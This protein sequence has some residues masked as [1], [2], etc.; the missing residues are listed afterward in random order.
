MGY[1]LAGRTMLFDVTAHRWSGEI[2]EAI[3]LEESRLARALPSGSVSGTLGRSVASELGLGEGVRLVCGGHDQPCGALGAGVTE[4]GVAMYATGS[5]EC[6]TPAFREP[7]FT[8]ELRRNNLCT[9]DHAAAGMYTTVA[10]SLTGGNLL[11]WFRDQFGG[12]EAARAEATGGNAYALL[13]ETAGDEPSPLLALPYLT[14][15]GTPHF[16]PHAT[17][18]ILGLELTSTRG[19]VLR[20]LLEGVALEMRLNLEILENSGFAVHRLRAIGGGAKSPR[21]T[22][23]K[24]DVIGKSVEVLNITEAGCLGAALLGCAACTGEEVASLAGRW[25]RVVGEA[26]PRDEYA[27]WYAQRFET[28]KGLY[29]ALKNFCPRA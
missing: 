10:F 20:A 12:V 22:Q 1:P 28:Y 29:P 27:N 4:P 6:I 21:W 24:A 2:L 23:L 18:A 9:Y 5:V 11:K 14:P 26:E 25:T 13:L 15:T 7:V 16:D 19:Q 17:G 8:E 3:G